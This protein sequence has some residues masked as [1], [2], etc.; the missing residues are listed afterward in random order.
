[1]F[2]NHSSLN[3]IR[4]KKL[5]RNAEKEMK[6]NFIHLLFLG[7]LCCQC[8]NA[9]EK[10][11]ICPN[12]ITFRPNYKTTSYIRTLKGQKALYFSGPKYHG[13][14]TRVFALIGIP[15]EIHGKMLPGIVLVHG[16]GGT[17]NASWI[18]KWNQQGYAA[19][20][21]D[22]NGCLPRPVQDHEKMTWTRM[23]D[24]G[25]YGYEASFAQ[26]SKKEPLEEQW[27]NYAVNALSQAHSLLASFAQ[28]DNKKIGIAGISWGGYLACIEASLDSRYAFVI[29]SYGCG[30][31]TE[32]SQRW[33]N[34]GNLKQWCQHFDP[35]HYLSQLNMPIFWLTGTRDSY[36]PLSALEKSYDLVK[37][38]VW[39]HLLEDMPHSFSAGCSPEEIYVFANQITKKSTPLPAILSQD[40]QSP[41]IARVFYQSETKI[42]KA[43]FLYTK[44]DPQKCNAKNN[45]I[46]INA[47][48]NTNTNTKKITAEI[49]PNA[50]MFYF[51]LH[52]NRGLIVS[53]KIFHKK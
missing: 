23:P 42:V 25:P 7:M 53:S 2:R 14:P 24:G 11:T 27:P 45:W 5:K 32:N 44:A 30:F 28:V 4:I 39:L 48:I 46:T 1:M 6:I 20:A 51:N 33:N 35:A 8:S 47:T 3:R 37:S 40:L 36:Y 15:N 13:R 21:I 17:A 12:Y 41:N 22:L 10:I 52:D 49:P 34:E 50:Q 18:Q 26:F 31:L 19:I 38:P 43:D 16:E 29:S 9:I